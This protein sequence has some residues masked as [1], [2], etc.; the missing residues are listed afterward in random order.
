MLQPKPGRRGRPGRED[1]TKA[2]RLLRQYRRQYPAERPAEHWPRMYPLVIPGYAGMNEG[3][4]GR[5]G[6]V[7][8]EGEVEAAEANRLNIAERYSRVQ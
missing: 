3:T 1:V 5:T 4:T 2:I 6:A 8:G 7:E